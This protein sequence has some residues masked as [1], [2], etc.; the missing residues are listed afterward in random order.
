[1]PPIGSCISTLGSLVVLVV[2]SYGVFRSGAFT[3]GIPS[4]RAGFEG[5]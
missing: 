1:M 2:G 3:E 5:L 4:L